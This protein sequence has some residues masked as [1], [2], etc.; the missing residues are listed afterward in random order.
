MVVSARVF[1]FIRFSSFGGECSI[2]IIQ[3]HLF[4]GPSFLRTLKQ[5]YIRACNV[6]KMDDMELQLSETALGLGL[7]ESDDEEA[8]TLDADQDVG[9]PADGGQDHDGESKESKDKEYSD[10]AQTSPCAKRSKAPI[11]LPC[12]PI[13]TLY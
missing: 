8:R 9:P 13:I 6:D 11:Q 10:E 1:W 5:L 7:Q 3:G 12:L 4:G 2:E